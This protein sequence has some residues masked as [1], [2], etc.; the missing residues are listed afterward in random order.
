MDIDAEL[1]C[2]RCNLPLKEVRMSGRVF[3]ACDNCGGRAVTV[4]LLRRT[5]TPES[6]NP[7]WLHAMRAQG[8]SGRICPSCRK[9]MLDVALSENAKVDVDVCRHCHFVWFDAHEI[10][11]LVPQPVPASAPEL[12]QEARKQIA[13]AKV[14]QL[15]EEARGSDFD[16]APPDERWKQIAAFFGL[17]VEFDEPAQE[18]TPWA[19]WLLAAAVVAIS[20][21]AFV[22]LRETVQ[23]FGLI[24]AEASRLDGLTFVTSFFLHAGIIH[25]AGNMYFLLV[26]GDNVE[27]FLRPFR[28]LALIA[29]AAFVGDL[30]HIGLDPHSQ[31]PCIGASGG[32]AGVIT[33]YALQFPYVRLGFLMRWGFV[34]F[35]WI[36]LPAW[37]ALVLWILFQL[38][39]AW[40]QKVGITSVS[41]VAHLGGA[42]V[43][44]VL[45]LAW[46]K[47]A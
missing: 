40:E 17:P 37:F 23:R 20:A 34:W 19:T 2:P 8:T 38:I 36:R 22:D 30:A 12:S 5:F 35:R 32:I 18:R 11:T 15:A 7:L 26:F 43:G 41:A 9:P 27:N 46:R 1:I 13:I 16:S 47:P 3:W 14:Q 33:F 6:I 29:L 39:V 45:W 25:L 28:Y 21:A 31:T 4:E 44:L 10:D 24:P 42:A